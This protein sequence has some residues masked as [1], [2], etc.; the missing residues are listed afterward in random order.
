L[1][2]L[3][4]SDLRFDRKHGAL[5]PTDDARVIF[6][7][8]EEIYESAMR[9]DGLVSNLKLGKRR[10]I[11]FCSSPALGL[12]VVPQAI[13]KY[14]DKYADVAF[15]YKTLMVKDMPMELLGKRAEFALSIWPIEHPNLSCELLFESKIVL[16]VPKGHALAVLDLVRL[17]Q[18]KEYPLILYGREMPMGAMIRNALVDAGVNSEPIVEMNRSEL[19]CSLVHAGVGVAL[20]NRSCVDEE[21]WSGLCVKEIDV[22]I[23]AVHFITGPTD[24]WRVRRSQVMVPDN[25]LQCNRQR[26]ALL[27]DSYLI[28][29]RIAFAVARIIDRTFLRKRSEWVELCQ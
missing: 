24:I 1:L 13:K 21:I 4:I 29:S 5:R 2:R 19:A 8:V 11:S 22:K 25:V 10:R 12:S 3:E 7:E 26:Q 9:V 14:S 27:W 16:I 17:D 23:S 6:R 28:S 15:S 18:L 20:V